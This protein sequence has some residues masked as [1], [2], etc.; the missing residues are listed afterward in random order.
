V[1]TPETT[2]AGCLNRKFFFS[3]I[4]EYLFAGKL[5]Q[6][7][8]EGL[9]A[10]LDAWE[11]QYAAED[12]RWFAYMLGTAHHETGQT[13]RPVVERGGTLYL[14]KR[15]D[16]SGDDP[17]RARRHGNTQ[18]GD[19]V[20]YAGRGLVQ[21]TWKSNYRRAGKAIGINL[22]EE[23][24]LALEPAVAQ[25]ILLRGMM[26]GWYTGRHLG[27]FFN[28]EREDWRNARRVINGVDQA[29]RIAEYARLYYA[30]LSYT[31]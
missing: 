27:E 13:L 22:E 11:A 25:Q 24:G 17:D 9:S 18:V 6:G 1:D 19:G 8:V 3:F 29:D 30:A 7:Q 14:R 4:R 23:P 10:L 20:R 26:E 31:V 15:Y 28:A 2:T 12:D 16:I 21:L 5:R